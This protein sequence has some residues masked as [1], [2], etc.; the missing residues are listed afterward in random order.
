MSKV[1]ELSYRTSAT[2]RE[3]DPPTVLTADESLQTPLSTPK[4]LGGASGPGL[5][6]EEIL[7]AAY[8]GCLL[9]ALRREGLK[10]TLDLSGAEVVCTV[11][12]ESHD[13][14]FALNVALEVSTPAL[15]EEQA[16][17]LFA[18]ACS[19]WPYAEGR[20][21]KPPVV[22][23]KGQGPRENVVREPPITR[24]SYGA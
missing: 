24:R 11:H 1:R 10:R 14:K 19:V 4:D 8:A 6:P 23:L 17:E 7:A 2:A 16:S 20:S 5:N 22:T 13:E 15:A 12:L 9:Q 18:A 21:L 3:G